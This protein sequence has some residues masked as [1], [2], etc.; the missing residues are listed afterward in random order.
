MGLSNAFKVLNYSLLLAKFDAY[1]FSLK[2]KTFIQ[3]YINKRIPKVNV[4]NKSSAWEYIYRREGIFMFNIFINYIF[5]FLTTCDM[6]NCADDN[7]TLYTY[8]RDIYQVQEHL[9]KKFKSLGKWF[10][11]NHM[12][13][14]L[15]KC[16]FMG[17]A[18]CNGNEVFTYHKIRTKKKYDLENT[19]EYNRAA[20]LFRRTFNKCMQVC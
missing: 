13:L 20:C 10:C 3:S 16:Q 19:W 9:K 15:H 18:K 2:C 11:D 7:N 4:N 5:R 6:R 17:F 12:V 14:N 8:S 1:G